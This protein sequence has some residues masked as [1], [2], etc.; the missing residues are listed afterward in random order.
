[1]SKDGYIGSIIL[2]AA[3]KMED[4]IVGDDIKNGVKRR[5]IAE[6][7]LQD[8]DVQNRNKRYYAKADIEKELKGPRWQELLSKKRAFGEAGHPLSDSLV[9][10]QTIDPKFVSVRYLKTWIEG[11]RVKAQFKGANNEYGE[12]FDLDLREGCKPSFSLRALGNIENVDGK[13]Y[14]KNVK[15]ITFDECL[16]PS[17]AV[18]YTEKIISENAIEYEKETKKKMYTTEATNLINEMN[19]CGRVI[20]IGGKEALDTLNKL[21]RESASI[22]AILETFEG[23]ADEVKVV[24]NK[25]RLRTAFGE[26]M[27]LPLDKYVSNLITNY[28]YNL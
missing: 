12:M 11:N 16:Y 19:D 1:M 15:I 8:L 10:Q 20:H 13:A 27:Y 25:I 14:V 24:G 28:V 2:E 26:T 5:V 17:H 18:A 9:R 21:Q 4:V 3:S 7:T 23:I 6:G 22:G